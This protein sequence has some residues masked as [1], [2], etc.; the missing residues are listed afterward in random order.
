LAEEE[1]F[2]MTTMMMA[3]KSCDEVL[4]G[5]VT[6]LELSRR[7][8]PLR[9]SQGKAKKTSLV[10]ELQSSAPPHSYRA[11]RCLLLTLSHV[12]AQQWPA[13]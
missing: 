12:T 3:G 4:T 1:M 9:A 2:A 6:Q 10:L 13:V 5:T 11:A 8:H 7:P